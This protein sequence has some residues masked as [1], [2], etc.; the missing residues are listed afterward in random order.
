MRIFIHITGV[1]LIALAG[2]FSYMQTYDT[3]EALQR[4]QVLQNQ[5]TQEQEAVNILKGE[6]AYLNRPDRLRDLVE[7]NFAQLQLVPIAVNHLAG[8]QD[9]PVLRATTA[10]QLALKTTDAKYVR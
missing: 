2:Y 5:I 9:F 3:R 8:L 10:Y 7:L 4:V 6:W 1:I